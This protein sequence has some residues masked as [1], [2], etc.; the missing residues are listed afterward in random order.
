M[1]PESTVKENQKQNVTL[2]CDVIRGNPSKLV[3]VK[4]L[5]DGILLTELPACQ[6]QDEN[7]CGVDPSKLILENVNREFKGSYS[8]VGHNEVG[9]SPA[10]TPVALEVLY[11]PGEAKVIAGSK[12]VFKDT[13]L[14]LTCSLADAGKP[15]AVEYV[16]YVGDTALDGNPSQT[17]QINPVILGTQSNISCLAINSVGTGMK[18]FLTVDVLA[19]PKFLQDL[20]PY[21]GAPS[22]SKSVELICQVECN[23]RCQIVWLKNEIP[24]RNQER[25]LSIHEKGIPSD[26]VTNTF[27]SVVSILTF[28]P[29]GTSLSAQDNAN[30]TCEGRSTEGELHPIRS[31]TVFRHRINTT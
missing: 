26:P 27:P 16:W 12:K 31:T 15:S 13:V 6:K 2:Y 5:M 20:S 1:S 29:H 22:K 3:R 28:H 30:Y 9:Q 14:N 25:G 18:G 8:C 10:S 17:W 24:I 7:L 11:P 23:P 4:W 19:R 21:T